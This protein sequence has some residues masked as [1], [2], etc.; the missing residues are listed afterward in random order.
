[1]LQRM[2]KFGGQPYVKDYMMNNHKA[3]FK[4]AFGE[5]QYK[6]MISAVSGSIMGVGEILLLPLGMTR[7]LGFL[8][9]TCCNAAT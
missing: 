5:K 2:Y 1:M 8:L 4:A 7:A 9:S 3:G 6:T